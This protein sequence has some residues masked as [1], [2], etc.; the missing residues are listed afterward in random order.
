[1]DRISHLFNKAQS[2]ISASRPSSTDFE[3]PPAKKLK[4]AASSSNVARQPKQ[5]NS[6]VFEIYAPKGKA[7][8]EIVFFHGLQWE[9]SH[10]PHITIWKSADGS[11][12]WLDWIVDQF[13]DSRLLTIAYDA[14]IEK[15]DEHGNMDMYQIT[16][17]LVPSLTG[18]GANVGQSGCPVILVGHCLGGLVMKELCLTADRELHRRSDEQSNIPVKN[19]LNHLKGLFFFATP[20][21]GTELADQSRGLA[22]SSLF[23]SM[24]T[25]NPDRARGNEDFR[26]LRSKKRWKTFV[27]LAGCPGKFYGLVVTEASARY[28]ADESYTDGAAN[29]FNV[30]QLNSKQCSSFQQLSYFVFEVIKQDKSRLGPRITFRDEPIGLQD[31]VDSVETLVK[32]APYV[33]IVGMGGIGKTTLAKKLFNTISG[34]FEFTCFVQDAR[35][36]FASEENPDDLRAKLKQH[37]YFRGRKVYDDFEWG[38]LA[39]KSVLIVLDNIHTG[40]YF[41][42][43]IESDGFADDSRV[44]VTTRH[45]GFLNSEGFKFHFVTELNEH[46]SKTL[47]CLHAFKPHGRLDGFE[48]NVE[49][50]SKLCGGYPLAIGVV[51][52]FLRNRNKDVWVLLLQKL[53]RGQ[54]I[55]GTN[56]GQDELVSTLTS[57]YDELAEGERKMLLDVVIFF[58]EERLIKAKKIWSMCSLGHIEFM[59]QNLLDMRLVRVTQHQNALSLIWEVLGLQEKHVQNFVIRMP[60]L[61]RVLFLNKIKAAQFA[62]VQIQSWHEIYREKYNQRNPRVEVLKV[63]QKENEKAD[64]TRLT[65]LKNL[66]IL[67]LDGGS[68]ERDFH[69]LPPRLVYLKIINVCKWISSSAS[70]SSLQKLEEHPKLQYFETESW[71]DLETLPSSLGQ[72]RN[73]TH[74]TISQCSNLTDIS[75]LSQLLAL[76][77]LTFEKCSNLE[78]LP[79]SL[80]KLQAL[81]Y[82]KI[83]SCDR[84]QGL[85]HSLGQLKALQ[86]LE[87]VDCPHLL[88]PNT[89]EPPG[90][91]QRL[92]S[93]V[94]PLVLDGCENVSVP[95]ESIWRL[96]ALKYLDVTYGAPSGFQEQQQTNQSSKDWANTSEIQ[97]QKGIVLL[98]A[99]EHIRISVDASAGD[100]VEALPDAFGELVALKSM[101]L[102][103]TT[104]LKELPSNLSNLKALQVLV[105]ED[106]WDLET[107]PDSLWELSAL[108]ILT[109][110]SWYLESLSDSLG[111]LGALERLHI[112]APSLKALPDSIR[113]LSNL[114][115]LHISGGEGE[116]IGMETLSNGIGEL[117]AL[118]KLERRN[119]FRME[120]LPDSLQGLQSLEHLTVHGFSLLKLLP[121]SLGALQ[122]ELFS[123]E[124]WWLTLESGMEDGLMSVDAE[125]SGRTGRSA[126]EAIKF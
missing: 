24:T 98:P 70:E 69:L 22:M 18:L 97:N 119:F 92:E 13:Q 71:Q 74:L 43:M 55:D 83:K 29:H 52:K 23:E 3:P 109:I 122:G 101:W 6:H 84:L 9:E 54:P 53:S 123:V 124:I 28:D 44:I 96:P 62:S 108:K 87:I 50:I 76:E 2:F 57:S 58:H 77:D 114:E 63:I 89:F 4:L 31:Q 12:L 26:K 117:H 82:L 95:G 56:E 85:P 91:F 125:T 11:Q 46:H 100:I 88:F 75:S 8:V 19:F 102:R 1:M 121:N 32:K 112:E 42:V 120:S 38:E 45:S 10:Q 21:H 118:K 14:Q 103:G 37:L 40:S 99:L 67:S 86:E 5:I 105:L 78:V 66:R 17:N 65:G 7:V 107:L 72:L 90:Q 51:G 104:G 15:T 49:D 73:L 81:K 94:V 80:E 36:I 106:C 39:G 93:L 59:W 110:G 126:A 111:M 64:L 48:D 61:L 115:Y 41:P 116:V 25:L 20:H 30:C 79:H 60:E 27:I 33:A 35:T 68:F 34:Q 47:L 113:K 16:E